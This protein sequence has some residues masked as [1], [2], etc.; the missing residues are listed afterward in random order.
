[1]NL[2]KATRCITLIP[3]SQKAAVAELVD[4]PDL[5]SVDR[6][7]VP[8]RFR[9]AA[10]LRRGEGLLTYWGTIAVGY[11]KMKEEWACAVLG[12]PLM[13]YPYVFSSGIGFW[14]VG[15]I[16]SVLFFMPKRI[17]GF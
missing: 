2:V 14:V 15:T 10:L 11:A 1:M 12:F 8:V 17:L 9:A 4:A 5:K 7:V 3:H 16:L 13:F 6:K